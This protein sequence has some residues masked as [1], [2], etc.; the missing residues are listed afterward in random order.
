MSNQEVLQQV[1]RSYRMPQPP[2]CPDK[3]YQIM[4][5]CWKAGHEER[6]TFEA[7]KWMLENFFDEDENRQYRYTHNNSNTVH[8]DSRH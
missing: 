6:P 2:N 5:N 7:L 4:L 3:L 8:S 1:A